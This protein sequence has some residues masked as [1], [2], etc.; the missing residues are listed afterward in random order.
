MQALLPSTL[1]ISVQER[2]PVL[3]LADG[4][5]YMVDASGIILKKLPGMAVEGLPLVTGV[6]VKQLLADRRPLLN[7]LKL[8]QKIKEVDPE[9]LSLVSEIH[10]GPD[11]Y[12]ELYLVQGGARVELGG[13]NYYQRLYLLSEFLHNQEVRRKLKQIKRIDL[14]FTNKVI[15]EYKS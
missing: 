11:E 9:L 13:A 14:T 7:A 4:S 5:L 15:V 6:T 2:Q 3:L 10:T 1:L 8:V 12:P